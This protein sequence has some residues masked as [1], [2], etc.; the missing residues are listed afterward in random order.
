MTPA[1]KTFRC[2]IYARKSTDHNLDLEFNSL[3]TQRE[4]YEAYIKSQAHE[5]WRL[6]PDHYDDGAYS[7]TSLEFPALQTLLAD[8]KANKVARPTRVCRTLPS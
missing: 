8:L 4:A 2:A 6:M 7:G 5:G 3:D 1:K